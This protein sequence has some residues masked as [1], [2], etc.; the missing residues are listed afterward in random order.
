MHFF[1]I[2]MSRVAIYVTLKCRL[3]YY[4]YIIDY[5]IT[6]RSDKY[7]NI[8]DPNMTPTMSIESAVP[9]Y[10]AL[11]HTKLNYTKNLTTLEL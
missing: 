8:I 5:R 10:Q 9:L 6:H 11:S 1:I 7:P 3:Y 2:F 4:L